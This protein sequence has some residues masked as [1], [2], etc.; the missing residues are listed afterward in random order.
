MQHQC[1]LLELTQQ[2]YFV[3]NALLDQ[4]A[5]WS[6]PSVLLHSDP[7]TLIKMKVARKFHHSKTLIYGKTAV[8][9]W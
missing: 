4:S 6:N 8:N 1:Q 5:K 7:V 9:L 3:R 2:G